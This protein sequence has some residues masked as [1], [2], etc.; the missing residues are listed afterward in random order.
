[1]SRAPDA[2]APFRVTRVQVAVVFYPRVFTL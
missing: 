2:A 1:M